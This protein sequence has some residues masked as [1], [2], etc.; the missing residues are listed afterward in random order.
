LLSSLAACSSSAG[1][2]PTSTHGKAALWFRSNAD[3]RG[4]FFSLFFL[5]PESS[6]TSAAAD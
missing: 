1:K 5:L 4:I 2:Q 3:V 6:I